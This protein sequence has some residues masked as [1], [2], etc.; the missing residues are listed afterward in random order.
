[1]SV[2]TPRSIQE[3]FAGKGILPDTKISRTSVRLDKEEILLA[4]SENLGNVRERKSEGY[5]MIGYDDIASVQYFGKNLKAYWK[6]KY[7]TIGSQHWPMPERIIK[8]PCSDVTSG[9]IRL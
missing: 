4:Y 6:K 2:G 9:I 1:M 8:K 5:L 3:S 7:P